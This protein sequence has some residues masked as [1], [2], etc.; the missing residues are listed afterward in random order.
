MSKTTQTTI[1]KNQAVALIKSSNGKIFTTTFI[2]KDGT[3]RTI[4][5]R[6]KVKKNTKGGKNTSEPLG[7]ITM[8]SM[9]DK[10][11]KNMDPRTQVSLSI[12]GKQ[13]KVK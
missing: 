6:I 1:S 9:K 13:Y 4:N 8:Y 7:Y 11:Y 5:G 3:A 10:G 2:K 12:N